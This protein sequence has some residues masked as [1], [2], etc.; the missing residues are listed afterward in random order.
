MLEGQEGLWVH[1]DPVSLFPLGAREEGGQKLRIGTLTL[2]P[3]S[4]LAGRWLFLAAYCYGT[5]QWRFAGW[6]VVLRIS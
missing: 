1:S 4:P 3:I 5:Q 6:V 2:S